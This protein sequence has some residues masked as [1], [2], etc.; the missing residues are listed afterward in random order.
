MMT[1]LA[2]GIRYL[3]AQLGDD[4]SALQRATGVWGTS[5]SGVFLILIGLINLAALIGIL[6]DF[7]GCGRA[8]STRPS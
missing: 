6:R 4:Q 7:A 3:A 8:S 2:F 5:V 1:L